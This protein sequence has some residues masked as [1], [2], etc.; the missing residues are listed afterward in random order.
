M[1]HQF[2]K[3][4]EVDQNSNARV[5]ILDLKEGINVTDLFFIKK[6]KDKIDWVV[7]RICDHN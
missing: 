5:N 1:I 4:F 2:T 7:N 6:N 3:K